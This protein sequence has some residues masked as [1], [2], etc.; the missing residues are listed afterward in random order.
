MYLKL[1]FLPKLF[2]VFSPY[3]NPH[4]Q[5]TKMLALAFWPSQTSEA[6]D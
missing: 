1:S 6:K 4:G 3:L 2:A 5:S